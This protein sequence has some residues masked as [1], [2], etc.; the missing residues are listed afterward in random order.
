MLGHRMAWWGSSKELDEGK[1]AKGQ[2][3]LQVSC[4]CCAAISRGVGLSRDVRDLNRLFHAL[5]TFAD[6]S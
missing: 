5:E 1:K 6:A 4:T 2:L 3:L